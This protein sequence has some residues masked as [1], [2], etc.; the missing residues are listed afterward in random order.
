MKYILI[1]IICFISTIDNLVKKKIIKEIEINKSKEI[2]KD[3]IY[4]THIK[5]E[6]AYKN[7]LSNNKKTLGF[8]SVS[9]IVVL[10]NI[11]F[12]NKNNYSTTEKIGIAFL[13]GG[14]IGN[15]Y[16]RFRKKEVTDFLEIRTKN[17]SIPIF[18]IADIFIFA[19]PL[20][21]ILN[22]LILKTNKC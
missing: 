4:L 19:S 11:L 6:G 20:L 14:G 9:L 3:K 12:S 2:I 15:M 7:L 10:L 17:N 13:I 5:N 18:N 8:I 22:R 1:F 21:I 16:E